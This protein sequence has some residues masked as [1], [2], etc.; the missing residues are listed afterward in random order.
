MKLLIL[1]LAFSTTC[2]A[3]DLSNPE[4]DFYQEGPVNEEAFTE[5]E[6][7]E[8]EQSEE[9]F[10]YSEEYDENSWSDEDYQMEL[11]EME[12]DYAE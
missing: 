1:F 3:Q 12:E 2:L 11:Q 5:E 8:I 6:L 9:E 4:L 10:P 7:R